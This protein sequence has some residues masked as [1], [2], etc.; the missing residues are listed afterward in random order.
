MRAALEAGDDEAVKVAH[1]AIGRLLA[2]PV[3]GPMGKPDAAPLADP[4]DVREEHR[5]ADV[6]DLGSA[7][8]KRGGRS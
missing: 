3:T 6:V 4:H 5:G 1:E 2:G 8:A 7:R